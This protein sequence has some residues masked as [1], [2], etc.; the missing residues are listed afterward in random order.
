MFWI[1]L[2]VVTLTEVTCGIVI[3]SFNGLTVGP[4]QLNGIGNDIPVSFNDL[5]SFGH[6]PTSVFTKSGVLPDPIPDPDT[7]IDSSQHDIDELG[8]FQHN[9]A[10]FGSFQNNAGMSL[11]TAELAT[12]SDIPRNLAAVHSYS[13]VF[14]PLILIFLLTHFAN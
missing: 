3:N 7:S 14:L 9:I 8:S 13:M 11:K 10:G 5:G 1:F 6:V 2:T 4:S 12:T